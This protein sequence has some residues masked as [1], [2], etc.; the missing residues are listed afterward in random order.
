MIRRSCTPT[1]LMTETSDR[2]QRQGAT[3]GS[4][5]LFLLDCQPSMWTS[6]NEMQAKLCCS[7]RARDILPVIVFSGDFPNEVRR[8]FESI[9]ALLAVSNYGKGMLNY[10]REIGALVQK[11]R[12]HTV[13]IG[14]FDYFSFVPW[15]AR[16]HGVRYVIYS[17]ENSGFLRA[18][19][20]KK[21]LIRLRARAM[22]QP[23]TRAIAR[24]EY[25]RGQ[26]I[27][28]GIPASKIRVV[29]NGI[30]TDRFSPD[31]RAREQ[32]AQRYAIQPDEVILTSI[33]FLRPFKNPQVIVEALGHLTGRGVSARLFMVGD[34]DIRPQLEELG[35]RL[36]VGQRI[37][38][39]GNF[40]KPES[41][42]QAS[43]IFVLASVGEAFGLVLA[44]ALACGVPV[45]GSR[46]GAIGEVVEDGRTGFLATPRDPLSFADAIERLARDM[47]L[48][49]DMGMRGRESVQSRFTTDIA[50][51][52]TLRV[53]DSAWNR[54]G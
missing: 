1:S 48:R 40:S 24:S 12:P 13:H 9:G 33:A 4:S 30:D 41:L 14:H 6:L 15:I 52:N 25:S 44:E 39:L 50:V 23:I 21:L 43:D 28:S 19:S 49:R 36:G 3:S 2:H 11:Y 32:W 51:E 26:M 18:K 29:Y 10:R 31:P 42:L 27:E 34:G 20:W 37:H 16:L 17:Q 46:S 53:Y 22:T 45:V 38:W 35:R 7:L 47:P 8:R 5:V 54:G